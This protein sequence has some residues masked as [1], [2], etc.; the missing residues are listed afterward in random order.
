MEK[1]IIKGGNKLKGKISVSGA[2]NVALKAIVAAC[3]TNEEVIIKN[4]PLISDVLVMTEIV[5]DLGGKVRINDHTLSIKVE[6]FNSNRIS[7]DRAAAVR[8]SFMLMV[9]LIKRYGKAVIPNPGGCRIGARPIDRIVD[10]LKLMG[11]NIIYESEDG[12][13]HAT[14][15]KLKGVK[16]TF[17]K[18]Y[19][20]WYR[21]LNSCG[22]CS[23]WQNNIGKRSRRTRD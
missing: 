8:T 4:I 21:N 14:T 5:E 17:T 10:G 15:S 7:L 12:Y 3:L 13:F 9:P 11:V 22:F 2:K 6:K 19:S 18:K 1:F 23:K 20:H 16:Y